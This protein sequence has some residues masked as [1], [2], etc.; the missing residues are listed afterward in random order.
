MDGVKNGPEGVEYRNNRYFD[1][2]NTD[3]VN[4]V[5]IVLSGR[6]KTLTNDRKFAIV[7][8]SDSHPADKPL[9]LSEGSPDPSNLTFEES[10][11][12]SKRR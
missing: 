12:V 11:H 10:S 7:S 5:L 2:W 8:G 3:N 6:Y 4:K 9:C 1:V